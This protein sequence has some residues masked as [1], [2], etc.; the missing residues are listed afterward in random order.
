[1]CLILDHR[2]LYLYKKYKILLLL[3]MFFNVIFK[4]YTIVL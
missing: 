2:S 1:M 3:H 4:F